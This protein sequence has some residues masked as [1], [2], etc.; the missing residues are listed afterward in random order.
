[1]FDE[2]K[3]SDLVEILLFFGALITLWVRLQ[4]KLKELD[5]RMAAMERDLKHV[6]SQDDRIMDKLEEISAQVQ[7]VKIQLVNKQ[8]RA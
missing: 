4:T 3:P 6:E 5:M 1:M 7:D 2:M 8:D